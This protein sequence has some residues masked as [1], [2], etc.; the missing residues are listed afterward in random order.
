[1][2][3]GIFQTQIPNTETKL[4]LSQL[5]NLFCAREFGLDFHNALVLNNLRKYH[6]K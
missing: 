1:M 5:S 3:T 4:S 2:S 6:N